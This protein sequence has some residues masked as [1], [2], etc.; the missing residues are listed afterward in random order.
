M[1]KKRSPS[2]WLTELDLPADQIPAVLILR[3]TRTPR[4]HFDAARLHLTDARG[5]GV[6]SRFG[7]HACVGRVAG[8][9][10]GFACVYGAAE[11]SEMVHVFGTLGTRA[12][13]HLGE[14]SALV[15][16]ASIGHVLAPE[17]AYCGE[18]AAVCYFPERHWASASSQLLRDALAI[19]HIPLRPSVAYTTAARFAESAEDDERRFR[20]GFDCVDVETATVYAVAEHFG[21]LRLSLLNVLDSP[22]RYAYLLPSPHEITQQREETNHQL[23]T[24]A[25]RLAVTVTNNRA[26]AMEGIN[27]P[28]LP[29][30]HGITQP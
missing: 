26:R 8:S 22:R 19:S 4:A 30:D 1:F 17:W 10:V 3:G 20:H 16:T 28:S 11:A 9:L 5:L 29:A 21:M 14:C 27:L 7:E 18:G 25:F 12:V 13:I 2:A 15:G 24:L 6:G 23:L